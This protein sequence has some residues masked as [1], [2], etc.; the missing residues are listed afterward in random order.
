MRVSLLW[1]SIGNRATADFFGK[2]FGQDIVKD[3]SRHITTLELID[4][5]FPEQK[6]SEK[7]RTEVPL[8]AVVHL[9]SLSNATYCLKRFVSESKTPSGS[10]SIW[11]SYAIRARPTETNFDKLIMRNSLTDMS[12]KLNS[13]INREIIR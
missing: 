10:C 12:P 8:L 4:G 1:H 2:S 9:R 3:C 6:S 5:D 13:Q 7:V 11:F